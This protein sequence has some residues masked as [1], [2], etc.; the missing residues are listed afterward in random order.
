MSTSTFSL[1][2]SFTCLQ[3]ALQHQWHRSHLPMA[4]FFRW[5]EY[6]VRCLLHRP[7]MRHLNAGQTMSMTL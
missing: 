3:L 1:V 7:L 4:L 5:Q 2:L 6:H